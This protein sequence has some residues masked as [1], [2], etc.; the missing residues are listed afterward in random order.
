MMRR[1]R[2][3]LDNSRCAR[4]CDKIFGCPQPKPVGVIFPHGDEVLGAKDERFE[5]LVVTHHAG[6]G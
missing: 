6:N 2:A 1:Y 5:H 3:K 4:L